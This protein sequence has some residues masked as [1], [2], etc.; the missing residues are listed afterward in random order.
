MDAVFVG[1]EVLQQGTRFW[2]AFGRG[3]LAPIGFS[4]ASGGLAYLALWVV[5]CGPGYPLGKSCR[6]ANNFEFV[7]RAPD[8]F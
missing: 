7:L 3:Y 4:E 6:I 1:L 2:G 8:E 5:C